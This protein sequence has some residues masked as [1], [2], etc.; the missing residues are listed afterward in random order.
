MAVTL[1]DTSAYSALNKGHETVVKLLERASLLLLP[2]EVLGEL[3]FGFKNGSRERL[4][5]D[6][7]ERF[8]AQDFVEIT[9]PDRATSEIYADLALFAKQNGK[10]VTH[11]D[12][13]ICAAAL[14]HGATVITLD[15]D[16]A[17]LGSLLG[18]SLRVVT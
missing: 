17:G 1:L 4:N 12:L 2:V 11:N 13:W 8:L 16:F 3:V 9:Q 6:L 14:Q 15:T 7:L 10:A 18:N 5:R